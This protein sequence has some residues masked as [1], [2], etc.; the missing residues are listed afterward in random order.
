MR[1]KRRDKKVL[2]SLKIELDKKINKKMLINILFFDKINF[3]FFCFFINF[4]IKK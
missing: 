4:S 2:I 3:R 1:T